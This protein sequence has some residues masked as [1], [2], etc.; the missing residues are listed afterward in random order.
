MMVIAL[1]VARQAIARLDWP[2][3][4]KVMCGL[5]RSFVRWSVG[6]TPVGT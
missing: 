2:S 4:C 6:F 3:E 1:M 5:A